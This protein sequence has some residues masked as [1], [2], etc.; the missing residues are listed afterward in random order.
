MI[1][2][3]ELCILC[4]RTEDEHQQRDGELRCRVSNPVFTPPSSLRG[5]GLPAAKNCA[6]CKITFVP[7]TP[8]Q[9]LCD[10]CGGVVVP[11]EAAR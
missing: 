9:N 7:A 10:H 8:D 6:R 4:K 2:A 3:P 1:V 5:A 11:M